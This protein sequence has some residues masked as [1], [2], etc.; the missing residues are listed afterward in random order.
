M[1]NKPGV[2]QATFA[3]PP[4]AP[5]E[6]QLNAARGGPINILIVDDEPKN[7]TVLETILDDPGY[8]LVRAESA[9]Q[10]L[11]ALVA[12]EFALLILDIRMPGMTGLELAQLI[13]ERKKTSLVPI[14]FLSAYYNEDQHVLDGYAAGA[15][16]YLQ[17]PVNRNVLRSKVAVFAE[18]H[19]GNRILVAEVAARRHAEE[20]LRELNRTLEA[21]VDEQTRAVRATEAQLRAMLNALPAAVYATD[22]DGHVTHFNP[23]TI[24]LSGR[25]PQL[26]VDR[27]CPTSKLFATDG[28]P[29]PHEECPMALALREGRV[30]RGVDVIVER[31][32]GTRIWV[33]PYPT[34]L[35]DEDGRIIGGINMLVDITASKQAQTELTAAM[36]LAEKANIAKSEFLSSMSHE[37]RTPLSAI[38]GFAQLMESAAPPPTPQ[39]MRSIEQILGSGWHLLALINEILDLALIE[40]GKL[41]LSVE[42]LALHDV[43]LECQDMV[44]AQAQK[45]GIELVFPKLDAA[46]FVNADRTRIKQVL[47][48]LLSNAI[49]YNRPNG[50]VVL[51]YD[52][53]MKS[54][55][56][57]SVRDSG[58]GLRPEQIALLFQQFNRLGQENSVEEGTGIGLVVCKRLIEMMGG[59]IGVESTPDVGSHFWVELDLTGERVTAP[60]TRDFALSCPE[61]TPEHVPPR[62]LLYV[63]DNPA[64]LM[65][66]EELVARRPDLQLISTTDGLRGIELARSARPEVILMDINLPGISGL[67]ALTILREDASTAHI[68]VVALSANAMPHDIERGLD[69]GFFRYLTKPIKVNKFMETLDIALQYA[70]SHPARLHP[71][72]TS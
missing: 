38:L 34:P 60:E 64:N 52:M 66:V 21:R 10:A 23:A 12:E 50:R 71:G 31:P 56:R 59:V 17:K 55:V 67:V 11:L 5:T 36:H 62:T 19:R 44:E 32:D 27:W 37:L 46:C 26:G 48:N 24:E 54:R 25:V 18:L 33:T 20:Q 15:V 16:D 14:I 9:D 3:G 35:R 4:P 8:R 69:A 53:P 70:A 63:E 49:K 57:I 7:L 58:A 47:I 51:E 22:A 68:P 45:R 65:L 1:N 43:I 2:G 41:A 28:T 29:L 39:Q 6:A 61:L 30:I 40:S 72:E 42:P 13:R